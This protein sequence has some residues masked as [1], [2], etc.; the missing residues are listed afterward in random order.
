MRVYIWL[1]LVGPKWEGGTKLG[2][3]SVIKEVLAYGD[4]D[5]RSYCSTSHKS[6]LQKAVFLP[7]TVTQIMC[8]LPGLAATDWG[9]EFCF[10]TFVLVIVCLFRLTFIQVKTF[11][12][13]PLA[14][15][16]FTCVL[17]IIL[18][19]AQRSHAS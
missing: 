12:L 17:D 1:P 16:S 13:S 15:C 4:D 19:D 18:L 10:H 3:L 2:K 8:R 9:W 6:K 11:C 14:D 7:R 5:Y